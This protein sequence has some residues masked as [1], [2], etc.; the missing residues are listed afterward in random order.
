M[1]NRLVGGK[2][3]D[4]EDSSTICLET[5]LVETDRQEKASTRNTRTKRDKMADRNT[6]PARERKRRYETKEGQRR[7]E[8][9]NKIY[10]IK[11]RSPPSRADSTHILSLSHTHLKKERAR[12]H[13]GR[14]VAHEHTDK[15]A[16]VCTPARNT[17]YR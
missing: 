15:Q 12:A 8:N 11:H 7:T 6:E 17:T 10:V 2:G 5:S 3:K 1:R 9:K 13:A 16:H 4:L 14:V